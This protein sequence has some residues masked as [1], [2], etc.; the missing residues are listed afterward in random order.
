MR[1][2]AK[3]PINSVVL[4]NMCMHIP[5][6]DDFVSAHEHA[7]TQHALGIPAAMKKCGFCSFNAIFCSFNS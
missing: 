3:C 2:V 6:R 5:M 7:T 1:I 4:S